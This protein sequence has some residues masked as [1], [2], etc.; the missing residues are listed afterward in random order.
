[1]TEDQLPPPPVPA[2]C[3]LR[4][5]PDMPLEV[6]SLRDSDLRRRSTGDEFKAAIVLWC[7]SWHQVPCGSL[8]DDDVELADLAGLGT[9]KPSVR[10]WQKLRGMALRG[11]FKASDGRLY[12]ELMAKKALNGLEAKQSAK[13]KREADAERLRNWRETRNGG[14]AETVLKRVSSQRDQNRSEVIGSDRNTHTVSERDEHDL[15]APATEPP[16]AAD[17]DRWGYVRT[18]AWVRNLVAAGC[19]IGA[20][21]WPA[22]KTICE[23]W[24]LLRVIEISATVPATERFHGQVEVALKAAGTASSAAAIA[25]KTRVLDLSA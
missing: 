14:N 2:D 3:D 25:K 13:R 11:W 8:P 6:A 20:G 5:F 10:T 24:P 16:P 4:Q 15:G 23:R 7:A 21:S 19:K 22:W 18:E 9:G 12:H 1:M 17:A